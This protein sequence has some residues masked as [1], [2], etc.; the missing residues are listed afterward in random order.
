M[1]S[2][3]RIGKRNTSPLRSAAF[4]LHHGLSNQR[5]SHGGYSVKEHM[6]IVICGQVSPTACLCRACSYGRVR[7]LLS[8]WRLLSRPTLLSRWSGF[9]LPVWSGEL[10]LG[11]LC[12]RAGNCPGTS[13]PGLFAPPSVVGGVGFG[14]L[15]PSGPAPPIRGFFHPAPPPFL[16]FSLPPSPSFSPFSMS[17]L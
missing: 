14:G 4:E 2:Y 11:A 5:I 15:V 3:Q 13:A 1:L 12:P 6:S 17:E 7:C 8:R 10:G 16:L 9:S